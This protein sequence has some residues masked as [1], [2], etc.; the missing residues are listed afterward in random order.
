MSADAQDLLARMLTLDPE[1]RI[2]LEACWAHPWVARAPR[3]EPPGVGAGRLYRCLTDPTSGAVLANEGVMAQLEALGADGGAI[4]RALRSRECNSLTATYH[5]V[6]EAQ[7]EAQ[8]QA[9]AERAKQQKQR[10][11]AVPSAADWQWDFAAI[12]AAAG[13]SAGTAASASAANSGCV[14]SAGSSS[15]RASGSP[16]RPRT[17]AAAPAGSPTRFGQEAA[18]AGYLSPG[19]VAAAAAWS[20]SPL[21][22]PAFQPQRA[23]QQP[24]QQA[25]SA[26]SEPFT[27]KALHAAAA[28]AS[29]PGQVQAADASGAAAVAAMTAELAAGALI[30]SS[31]VAT[32]TTTVVSAA[33]GA[34]PGSPCK[35]PR[36]A[37]LPT[38]LSPKQLA[39]VSVGR[40][41][42]GSEYSPQPVPQVRGRI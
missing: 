39:P 32:T 36:L 7:L 27:I 1:Q 9:A 29:G 12:S 3:W 31:A 16:A 17:A 10:A 2:T 37:P 14:G 19:R 26:D 20:P 23:Q 33:D 11:A 22:P 30:T 15:L 4:R 8:R 38:A 41:S 5:L 18:A 28:A 21:S 24:Q 34:G 40:A 35:S 13:A 42:S 6:L 25:A